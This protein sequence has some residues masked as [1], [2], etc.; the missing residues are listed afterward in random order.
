MSCRCKVECLATF[1]NSDSTSLKAAVAY[2]RTLVRSKVLLARSYLSH[3][4][5]EI[6]KATVAFANSIGCT[7][8][9]LPFE[10]QAF[11]LC[12]VASYGYSMMACSSKGCILLLIKLLCGSANSQTLLHAI[13][14]NKSNYKIIVECRVSSNLISIN[15]VPWKYRK[16]TRLW[17]WAICIW[18]CCTGIFFNE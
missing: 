11:C 13:H 18:K 14:T 5:N 7:P 17:H 15:D 3:L 16:I 1:I 8:D 6:S 10:V 9:I 2:T 12:V 4:A